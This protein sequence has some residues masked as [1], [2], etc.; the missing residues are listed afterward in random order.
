MIEDRLKE[1]FLS[2]F[3]DNLG[4]PNSLAN[5]CLNNWEERG[6]RIYNE[7][8][9]RYSINTISYGSQKKLPWECENC[10]YNWIASPHN[11]ASNSS[12]CPACAG[13]TLIPGKNDLETFC[14]TNKK[15]EYLIEEFVGL[16]ETRGSIK[17][18]EISRGDNRRVVW[19]CRHCKRMWLSS[20]NTRTAY[21]SGCPYCNTSGYTSFPEQYI[22]NSLK[23]VFKDVL[24][25]QKDSIKQYEYDIVIKDLNLCIEYSGAY[26][27]KDRTDRDKLKEEH[28]RENG[29]QFMQIY[30]HKGEMS[31]PDTYT[32]EKII[33]KA[34]MDKSKHNKQLQQIVKYILQEYSDITLYNKIDFNKSEEE[35]NKAMGKA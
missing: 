23:Q 31:A 22:Y 15:F 32:K 18:N 11:R 27:H 26:W 25:R 19:R 12:N 3:K 6:R 8:R 30:M 16:D 33:Y 35:A 2:K 17:I 21:N 13:H 7:Y 34:N 9:S 28:C 20:P 1:E 14:K 24:S 5:Y 10:H 4:K 29:A